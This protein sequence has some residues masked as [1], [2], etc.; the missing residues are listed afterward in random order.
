MERLDETASLISAG[1]VTG[2]SV[3]NTHGDL[4]GEIHD[5]M[6]DKRSGR[7]AYAVMSFG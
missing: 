1:K 6:L 3:Y 5:V 4:L 2:T 7:I